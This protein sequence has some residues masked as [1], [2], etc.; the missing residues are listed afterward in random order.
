M[1]N[2]GQ[3]SYIIIMTFDD[4]LDKLITY[5]TVYEFE[6]NDI[7]KNYYNDIKENEGM[8]W[9]NVSI[10]D[11]MVLA[12]MAPVNKTKEEMIELLTPEEKEATD[13]EIYV[14]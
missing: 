10:N 14:Y 6:N 8:L 2:Y 11:N 9:F 3:T 13:V 4:E 12:N 7:A 1:S 5:R